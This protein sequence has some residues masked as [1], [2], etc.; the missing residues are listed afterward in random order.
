MAKRVRWR[1]RKAKTDDYDAI[2]QLAKSQMDSVLM[3]A[4][5]VPVSADDLFK[6]EEIELYVVETRTGRMIGFYG[7]LPMGQTLHV[8]TIVLAPS[9][10]GCGVGTSI[11]K[12]IEQEAIRRGCD[13]LELCVQTT[14]PRAIRLYKR[15]GFTSYGLVFVS[16]L[17]MHK[18]I[19]DMP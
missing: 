2:L 18:D 4:W 16:T 15:L 14:N 5:G 8:H 11:M 19:A 12:A 13:A 3:D 17:L 1:K 10:Q 6:V 9:V 7:L